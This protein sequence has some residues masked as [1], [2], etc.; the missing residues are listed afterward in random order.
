MQGLPQHGGVVV[1]R[2]STFSSDSTS[3]SAGE[4]DSTSA[5]KRPNHTGYRTAAL[6][7]CIFAGILQFLLPSLA[8]AYLVAGRVEFCRHPM[9]RDQRPEDHRCILEGVHT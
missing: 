8:H 6:L 3:P 4:A 7:G 5:A 1:Q 2:K 9:P